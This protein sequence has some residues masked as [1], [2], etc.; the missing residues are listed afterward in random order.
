VA[1]LDE[2]D[3]IG[4]TFG[5]INVSIDNLSLGVETPAS[6]IAHQTKNLGSN[7]PTVLYFTASGVFST[8]SIK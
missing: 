1:I 6:E 5:D 4:K 3:H 2:F 8:F 7:L